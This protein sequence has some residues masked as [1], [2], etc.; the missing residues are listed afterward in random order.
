MRA[1][2]GAP[3]RAG[4]SRPANAPGPDDEATHGVAM[5]LEWSRPLAYRA[6]MSPHTRFPLLGTASIALA[7]LAFSGEADRAI[8]ADLGQYGA[9]P[10][11][12]GLPPSPCALFEQSFDEALRSIRGTARLYRSQWSQ[13]HRLKRVRNNDGFAGPDITL[14]AVMSAEQRDVA[15]KATQVSISVASA[16]RLHC[17]SAGRLNAI[18]NAASRINHEI[19]EDAIWVDPRSFW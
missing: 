9:T 12:S 8:A 15:I 19:A 1:G 16:R 6:G 14:N 5:A 3:D 4:I 7:I 11:Y 2:R 17:S 18:D 13:F 10:S